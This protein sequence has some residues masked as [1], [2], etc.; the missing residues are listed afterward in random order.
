MRYT[1]RLIFLSVFVINLLLSFLYLERPTISTTTIVFVPINFFI[2]WII[3]LQIDKY[4]LSKKQLK[5]TENVLSD[6]SY[7]L[8]S[9]IDAIGIVN[10]DGKYEFVNEALVQLYG[11][12]KEDFIKINWELHF[13]QDS[14]HFLRETLIPELRKHGHSKGEVLGVTKDGIT[15]PLAIS[16]SLLKETQKTILVFRDITQQKLQEEFLQ[17]RAEHNELTNLPNRHRLLNKLEKCKAASI[18]SSVLFIDLDRFKLTN[19]TLGHEVGD[20]LLMAVAERLNVFKSDFVSIYH[21]GGDEF[22]VVIQNSDIEDVQ[23]TAFDIIDYIKKP[24]YFNGTEVF[25]TASIGISNY[26]QHTA[27]MNEL[28]KMADTAM[29]YAKTDGKNTF[30]LFNTDLKEQLER[31]AMIE[32]E[33][34]KA[35]KNEELFIHYQPKFNLLKNNE[36]AGVEALIRWE[37]PI[38]GHVSPMEFIP[39][40]ED[41]G[42]I[43]EIGNWV[44]SEVLSQMSK[45]RDKGY[46]LVKFSVN[47]SQRQFRDSNLI[48]FIESSLYSFNINPSYLELEVTESVLENFELVIPKI[49]SL[50]EL[51]VGLSIDDFGTGYSSLNLLKNLPFDTLKIDQ[52]FV[53]DLIENSKDIS[54]IKT[55][56]AI[57]KTFNLNVVAEGIETEEHLNLLGQLSC[58]MG[59]GY[60][61]S[62][63]IDS[64]ELENRFFIN[65]KDAVR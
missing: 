57:G 64:E 11:F 54:L 58:P 16:L 59:Q 39:I 53:R 47:V 14:M 15:L 50:K 21:L 6:Y 49:T 27:N 24:F 1:W 26:P 34:R 12:E 62:K 20:K 17:H 18:E 5:S 29:Y 60:Y 52:S 48:P 3:G 7:A 30:K 43:I 56:I 22:I 45:L 42:L 13:T 23:H 4:L 65:Q 37:N 33:L 28:I 55:I 51:G 2:F 25:I 9:T 35:I 36:L 41:T 31:K 32:V 44:V 46:S 10:E 38:L 61:F 8:D 63:P 19:D 40:A